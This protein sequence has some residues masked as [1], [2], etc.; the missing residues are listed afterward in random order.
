ML[1]KPFNSLNF[2]ANQLHGLQ[3]YYDMM[4]NLKIEANFL[5]GENTG[6]KT[7]YYFNNKKQNEGFCY[8]DLK[9]GPFCYFNHAGDTIAI[10]YYYYDLITSVK[11]LNSGKLSDEILVSDK[12]TDFTSTYKNG[13]TAFKFSVKNNLFEGPFEINSEQGNTLIKCT[14][15]DFLLD[16][17]RIECYSDGKIYK[18]ESFI[19]GYKSGEEIYYDSTGKLKLRLNY[20]EDELNGDQMIFENGNLLKTYQ[21]YDGEFIK[22]K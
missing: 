14:Y 13:K 1:Q 7:G 17:S 21:Y 16:G 6:L 12:F 3:K 18:Q 8:N 5:A 20:H 9:K 4:G 10:L 19:K 11:I 2:I 22:V 15:K